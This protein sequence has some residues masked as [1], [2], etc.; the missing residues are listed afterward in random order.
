MVR[1]AGTKGKKTLIATLFL[2][3]PLVAACSRP[4]PEEGSVAATL[5]RSRCGACHRAYPPG[6]LKFAMWEMIVPRMEERM[7]AAGQ[8]RFAD[9]ERA[10]IYDYLR[11]HA[12]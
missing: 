10:T 6:A 1:D 9:E 11:R 4:L 3:A 12:G 7:R 2:A 8:P 5:Y